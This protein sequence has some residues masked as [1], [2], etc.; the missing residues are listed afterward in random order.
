MLQTSYFKHLTFEYLLCP[1]DWH[2]IKNSR[3]RT[4]PRIRFDL[5][6]LNGPTVMSALQAT[7]GGRFTP[8]A[9]LVDEEA[10][11]DFMV[12]HFNKAVTDTASQ[13]PDNRETR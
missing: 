7:I 3:K 5:E 13:G 12:T 6:K 4:Q 11:L 9:T 10:D 2:A 1:V 8:L